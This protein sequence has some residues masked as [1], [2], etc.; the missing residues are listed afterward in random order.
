VLVGAAV[1]VP[2]FNLLVPSADVLGTERF[3]APAVMVWAGVSR[4]LAGGLSGLVPASRVAVVV[5][6]AVGAVLA[7]A[8]RFAPKRWQRFVPSAAG[9]GI[10]MVMPGSS[11]ITMFAGALGAEVLRRR[12]PALA[13]RTLVP[14]AAGAI[15]GE[16][17]LGVTM[18]LVRA[19]G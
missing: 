9:L 15:A 3:P 8:E 7:L 14:L 6:L 17:I 19:A 18:A 5:G 12:R 11:S 4:V 2:A 10:A 13:G 16:S 1:V